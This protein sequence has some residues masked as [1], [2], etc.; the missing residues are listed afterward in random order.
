LTEWLN[1]FIA[2]G[3]FSTDCL[4]ER[5]PPAAGFLSAGAGVLALSIS[6]TPRDYVIWF[7]PELIG[8][9]TWA[10][11]P[12]KK[13][14]HG[15]LG[16]RL[17]P[18]HSFAAWTETVRG[19]SRRWTDIEMESAA[20]LRMAVLDVALK[21]QTAKRAAELEAANRELDDFAYVASHDLKAPLRVIDHISHWLEEDLA[22]HLNDE[23]RDSMKMLRE[24]V[25]RMEKLLDDL[26][27]YSRVG[28]TSEASSDGMVS[29][30]DMVNDILSLLSPPPDFKVTVGP[31][32]AKIRL[33]RMPVQ[34][35]LMNLV[36]NALKHHHRKQGHIEL[37]AEDR[38]DLYAFVIKDDGP[39]IPIKHHDEIF[40]IFR[41][42]KPRDEIEG[43]GMG[44]AIV[45]K[46]IDVAG[47]SIWLD[48][49]D[50]KGSTFHFTWPKP[51]DQAGAA[52]EPDA[53]IPS[54][55]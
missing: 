44:L 35:I 43:S 18:R 15:P 1:N 27:Q 8:T 33:P 45:R 51:K 46:H 25:K 39:G 40:K 55:S 13:L 14:V 23:T 38:G 37:T 21:Q 20:A 41:T 36:S 24:R 54:P 31:G 48:S 34:Q 4:S 9:V 3:I 32:F 30:A 29:G 12:T 19:Y 42:L 17:T 6:R 26:L 2:D 5:Y 47:G 52:R 16:A 7:L 10:G 50:G 28:R 53:D 22:A 49:D 11:D